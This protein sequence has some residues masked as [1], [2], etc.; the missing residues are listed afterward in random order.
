MIR[1]LEAEWLDAL[2]A[3][4][5]RALR[6][7]GDLARLNVLMGQAGLMAAALRAHVAASPRVIVDLGGGDG[8]FMLRVARKLAPIWRH[9]RVVSVDRGVVVGEATQ[10]A[11]HALGWRFEPVAMDVLDYL[12]LGGRADA[13]TVNLFLHHLPDAELRRL[14]ALAAARADLFVACETRRSALPLFATRCLWLLGCNDVTR[15]DAQLSV[16]AGFR[17]HE[18]SALWPQDMTW[19]L[20]EGNAGLF[21]HRF[22]A[23]RVVERGAS[24]PL[25]P[26]SGG[27]GPGVGGEVRAGRGI[28]PPTPDPSPPLASLVGGGEK[29]RVP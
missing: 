2:P 17:Q 3:A 4:D 1:H 27:E 6:S 24:V 28:D 25:P 7:R 12:E 21:S 18:L 14:F 13:I 29:K 26:R 10:T 11:F 8:S 15:H 5:D 19:R 20:A 9:V 16:R 23:R 22:V